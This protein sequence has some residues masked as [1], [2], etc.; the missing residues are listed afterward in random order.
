MGEECVRD[1]HVQ[2]VRPGLLLHQEW[3]ASVGV[4]P[5]RVGYLL[6]P[7]RML[8]SRLCDSRRWRPPGGQEEEEEKVE[9]PR[10]FGLRLFLVLRRVC[11]T[12]CSLLKQPIRLA[13]AAMGF[14]FVLRSLLMRFH[15]RCCCCSCCC[16]CRGRYR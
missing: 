2:L 11:C 6:L 7:P 8:L 4:G 5:P 12:S 3:M 13:T 14:L 16:S 10:F 1:Q 15:C 9:S